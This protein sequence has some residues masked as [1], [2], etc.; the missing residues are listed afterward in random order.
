MASASASASS[1]TVG[2]QLLLG[3]MI[4]A[5]LVEVLVLLFRCRL[6]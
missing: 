2:F 1:A 4:S 5:P 3:M 6:T